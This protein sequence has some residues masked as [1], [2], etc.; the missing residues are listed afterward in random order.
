MT[1][2]EIVEYKKEYGDENFTKFVEWF[3]DPKSFEDKLISQYQQ[4][5]KKVPWAK[6]KKCFNSNDWH[7][8][9][10]S[11]SIN[12]S[13]LKNTVDELFKS[14]LSDL[15]NFDKSQYDKDL[16]V[17]ISSGRFTVSGNAIDGLGIYFIGDFST[18]E[19][20]S[21]NF[22]Y[23]YIAAWGYVNEQKFEQKKSSCKCS[24]FLRQRRRF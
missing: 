13:D 18:V 5:L 19:N 10:D 9:F 15:I 12:V 17:H 24:K 4:T 22:K 11:G 1:L 16:N 6:I 8:G 7:Y 14:A 3:S 2:K 21:K 23:P 20:F